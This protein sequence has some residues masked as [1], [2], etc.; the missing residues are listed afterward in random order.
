MILRVDGL[1]VLKLEFNEK[2]EIHFKIKL[3]HKSQELTLKKLLGSI[4]KKKLSLSSL[5]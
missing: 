4:K 2:N 3:K 1:N 5:L